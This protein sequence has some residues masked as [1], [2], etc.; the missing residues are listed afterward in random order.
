M[1]AA[2][3][4]HQ[5]SLLGEALPRAST[6]SAAAPRERAG[7]VQ[8]KSVWEMDDDDFLQ[9][10][11]D[12]EEEDDDDESDSGGEEDRPVDSKTAGAQGESRPRELGT[13]ADGTL[14]G[15]CLSRSGRI[16]RARSSRVNNSSSWSGVGSSGH[17]QARN[18]RLQ[19][20][21]ALLSRCLFPTPR[22]R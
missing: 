16:R 22:S 20:S 15:A 17:E 10:D 7:A 1:L 4:A 3:E 9:E 5:A 12:E 8:P 14:T 18:A 21:S 19:G 11:D 13:P 2:L 6:S